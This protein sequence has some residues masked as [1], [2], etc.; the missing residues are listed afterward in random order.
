MDRWRRRRL[1]VWTAQVPIQAC[2]PPAVGE[3]NAESEDSVGERVVCWINPSTHQ[4]ANASGVIEDEIAERSEHHVDLRAVR[5]D[6]EAGQRNQGL[7]RSGDNR[8]MGHK[9]TYLIGRRV[10]P[11]RHLG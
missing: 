4:L 2:R 8:G 7:L 3:L 6:A 11:G 5:V 9:H 10:D 1:P